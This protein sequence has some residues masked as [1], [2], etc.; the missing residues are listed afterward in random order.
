MVLWV[1]GSIPHD[2]SIEI[3]LIS[4][5]VP[6]LVCLYCLQD[7]AYKSSPQSCDNMFPLSE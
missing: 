3:V 1:V 7:D 2:G 5:S 6:Q 4:A